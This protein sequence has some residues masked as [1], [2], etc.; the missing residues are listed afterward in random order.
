MKT[1]KDLCFVPK[2][3]WEKVIPKPYLDFNNKTRTILIIF[4]FA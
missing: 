3:T 1:R 4:F 2:G